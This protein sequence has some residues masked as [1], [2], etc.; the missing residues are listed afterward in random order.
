M[1][2]L[3][4]VARQRAIIYRW[5]SQLLFQELSDEGLLRLRNKENLALL[6]ALKSIPELS[7]L[8]THFQRRLRAMQKRE[9]CQL[10]LAADFA[11]LFLLPPPTG[12]SP[13]SGHYPHTTSPE[14]RKTLRQ[15]LVELRLTPQNNEAADHLAIQL[16]LIAT[17]IEEDAELDQ[18]ELFL[19][20]HLLSW[21]PL[22]TKR[23]YQRD[24]FGFYA[25]AMGLLTGF[26]QQDAEWLTACRLATQV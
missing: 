9:A 19:N 12:V 16:A 24:R 18:Q 23:C 3:D 21:L 14:E 1:S 13:Y 6:N 10:E 4:E 11:S 2:L 15:K 5:F 26:V 20:R 17:L 8:V 25:A 22:C 7:L